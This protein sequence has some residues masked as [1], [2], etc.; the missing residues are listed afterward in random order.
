MT[1]TPELKNHVKSLEDS[2]S[3][4]ETFRPV[5]TDVQPWLASHLRGWLIP[6][7]ANSGQVKLELY[8]L[9]RVDH[10]VMAP[11]WFRS[12]PDEHLPELLHQYIQVV[13]KCR[14]EGRT[15][16]ANFEASL[17]KVEIILSRCAFHLAV[18]LEGLAYRVDPSVLE[19]VGRAHSEAS[20]HFPV[21]STQ[22]SQAWLHDYSL[23]GDPSAAVQACIRA[24][25]ATMIPIVLPGRQRPI[26]GHAVKELEKNANQWRLAIVTDK[27]EDSIEPLL[28]MLNR[29][30]QAHTDRHAGAEE[31]LAVSV[32]SARS[33]VQLA[34]TLVQWFISGTVVRR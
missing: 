2:L 25:E 19:G 10:G 23:T 4:S 9:N 7:I 34:A 1:E 20:Q 15:H 6:V 29:L 21:A 5:L 18:T 26:Y 28:A 27:G 13:Q 33:C 3:G 14:L 16:P 24:V 11:D 12:I 31:R 22:L 30:G 17:Q 8:A 32:T